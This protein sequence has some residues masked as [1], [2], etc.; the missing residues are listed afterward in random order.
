MKRKYTC[1]LICAALLFAT[2]PAGCQIGNRDIVVMSTTNS[3]QVFQIGGSACSL[4]EARVYLCN[5]ANLYGTA[6]TIDLWQHDFGEYS[7]EDYVKDITLDKLTRVYCMDLLAES[8]EME[9]S[10]EEL[11]KT[12]EAAEEYYASLTWEEIHYMEVS[13]ADI[14]EYY[15]HYALA[16][17][18]YNSLTEEVNDEVSD[19]EARV[20]E[21]MQIFVSDSVKAMAVEQKLAAGDDF[22]AVAGN[23]NEL[24]SIQVTVTR[25][26]LPKQVEDVAFLLDDNEVTGRIEVENGYY[27]IKCLN[28]YNVE[29]TEANKSNIVEKREK[30]AFDDVYNAFVAGLSSYLNE[31]VWAEVHLDADEATTTTDFFEIY[32]KYCSGI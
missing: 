13:E 7:L 32:E 18:L 4:K 19:D 30:E 2:L 24:P 21:I 25:D 31:E 9:L 5:Y 27:F 17:K 29:L 14:R 6:Y 22:A 12:A 1:R 20:M 16:R 26:D 28:K 8:R 3:R 15:E 11:K 23:Y 10:E